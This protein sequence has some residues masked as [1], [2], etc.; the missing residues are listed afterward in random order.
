MLARSSGQYSFGD[1]LTMAD[2]FVFPQA[3]VAQ[4]RFGLH[5]EDYHHIKKVYD[6]LSLVPAFVEAHAINMPDYGQSNNCPTDDVSGE[7]AGKKD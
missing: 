3:W 2:A 4:E 5:M 1:C 6:N 7:E